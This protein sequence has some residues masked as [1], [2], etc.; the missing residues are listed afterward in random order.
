MNKLGGRKLVLVGIA[1]VTWMIPDA[2]FGDQPLARD[3]ETPQY[4]L[5]RDVQ[6]DETGVLNGQLIDITGQ[7]IANKVIEIRHRNKVVARSTTD[8]DGEF[9]LDVGKTGAYLIDVGGMLIS[10]RCWTPAA[11]PPVATDDLVLL[12]PEKTIR[13]QRPFADIITNPLFIGAVIAT[14][15]AIPIAVSN[16]N[17][18]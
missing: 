12:A 6:L 1:F 3:S 2:S 8:V 11:A 10:C 13:G 17:G 14:A 7:P 9:H 18:S 15:V 4:R 5:S 16:S